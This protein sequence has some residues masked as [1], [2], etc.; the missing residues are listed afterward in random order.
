MSKSYSHS[1][2]E[3][4]SSCGEKYR[5]WYIADP[6]NRPDNSNYHTLVG[7]H[8]HAILEQFYRAKDGD[9]PVIAKDYWFN[10]L[11]EAKLGFVRKM[12]DDYRREYAQ[13]KF[14][15]S[16]D[17]RGADAIRTASGEVPKNLAM[18][19]SWQQALGASGLPKKK[20]ILDKAAH[21]MGEVW[22]TVSFTEVYTDVN[23]IIGMHTKPLIIKDVV[24]VEYEFNVDLYGESFRGF[25]DLV[26]TTI[27]GKLAIID[28]KTNS[29]THKDSYKV[30]H[31]PQLLLYG[32]VYEHLTGRRPDAIGLGFLRAN[33]VVLADYDPELAEETMSRRQR[34]I[35]GISKDVFPMASPVQFNSPC[36]N[37]KIVC[38]YLERCHPKYA[39]A[40]KDQL[41]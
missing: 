2:L 20:D 23:E 27:D 37:G 5:L 34:L 24:D 22:K 15:A 17:Y 30:A 38:P 41:K 31:H 14:R 39:V 29:R 12:L 35:D 4:Y 13:L 10:F 16:K 19:Q 6:D 28:W 25:L 33:D 7:V 9:L 32:W 8:A 1:A 36:H 40:A 11:E 26:A 3:M 18:T 21:R